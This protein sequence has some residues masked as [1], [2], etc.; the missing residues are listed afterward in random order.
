MRET[1]TLT[2]DPEYAGDLKKGY[3]LVLRKAVT[4]AD[5]A[6]LE[7]GDIIEVVD[8]HKR[9]IGKGYHGNQN[10]GIGWVLSTREDQ[11]LDQAY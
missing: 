4:D 6:R 11:E 8:H 10:K 5:M 3:P 7:E 2:I 9:F 1:I